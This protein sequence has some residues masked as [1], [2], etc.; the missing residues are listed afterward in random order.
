MF[1]LF[2]FGETISIEHIYVQVGETI[3][4]KNKGYN[5][6]SATETNLLDIANVEYDG[7]STNY[8]ANWIIRGLVVGSMPFYAAKKSGYTR[9]ELKMYVIHV[10]DVVDISIHTN[11]SLTVGEQ[12]TYSPIITEM[13]SKTSL[14][15]TSNNT[16]VATINGNGTITATGVGKATITCTATNGVSTQSLVTIVPKL[17]QELTLD[18]QSHEMNVGE[19]IQLMPTIQP[20][21]ASSKQVKWFSS[22]ENIAQVDGEG[23]VTAFESGYCSI[24]ALADDGSGKFDR[25]LIH[26]SGSSYSRADVDGDGIVNLSDAQQVVRIFVGKEK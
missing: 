15:W 3:T 19:N 4:L 2:T 7:S 8:Y 11:V 9:T 1:T 6:W 13:Q 17:V 22:N 21:N 12:Y 25:C 14:T 5:T 10:V 26:V 16:A 18:K 23:N 24:Y 20:T